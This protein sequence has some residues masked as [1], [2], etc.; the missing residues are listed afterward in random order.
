MSTAHQHLTLAQVKPGM[1][2]SDQLL[3]KQGQ[4]LL[5]KGAV[6]TASI[7]ALLPKHGI[8]MLAVVPGDADL[9]AEPALDVA[10]VQARL[11]HLFRRHDPADADDSATAALR[12]YVEDYRLEREV[13]P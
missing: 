11:D 2:L 5:P 7:I 12:R 8:A 10:Q 1:V 6:L 3:D 4:V 13:G 9:M